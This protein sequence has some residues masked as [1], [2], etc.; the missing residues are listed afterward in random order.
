[1]LNI[2]F[3]LAILPVILIAIYIYKKDNNKEP[4]KLLVK[5]FFSGL[6][7]II[8]T[9]VITVL[10]SLFIPSLM[11]ANPKNMNL[12][13]LLFHVFIGVALVEEF[14]KWIMTYL[15]SYNN[16]EFDEIYD[17]I[18][19]SVFVSLGFACLENILYVSTGG[20]STAIGRGLLSI[21]GHTCF[22]VF[23]GY[24]F[25]LA[26]VCEIKKNEELKKKNMILSLA[27]PAI[28]HGIYDYC[29]F[30]GKVIFVLLF[31][32]FIVFMYMYANK[33]IKQYASVTRKIKYK[34]NYCPN[35]GTVVNNNYCPNCGHKND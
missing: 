12:I 1:M 19:Y 13:Q 2:N 20:L 23:M 21:P 33:K 11:S 29:L 15:I 26:K 34:N 8:I 22:G 7:S 6:I 31:L 16:E 30:T 10:L 24:Y 5:L 17:I 14:S 18:I 25:G 9:L 4:A 28:L 27:V 32:A 35:C 3:I